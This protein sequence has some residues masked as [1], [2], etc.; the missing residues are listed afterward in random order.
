M[1]LK[2]DSRKVKK[3]DTF[4]ALRGISSD[5]H[6]YIDKAISNGA[7]YI[8]AE[9]GEYSVPYKIVPDTRE[10]LIEYL[11]LNYSDKINKLKFI[12][13]T[14]TNGKTT[15]AFLIYNSLKKLGVKV[16]YIGTI[17]FYIDDK[18]MD[19]SNTT[20][21]IY[22]LYDMFLTCYN[23]GCTYVVQEISSQGLAY[24]RVEGYFFDYA[25]F[26][27]LTE[28]HLDFHK[29]M[30]NYC[31]AKQELFKK[32]K[33]DG[34]SIINNDDLYKDKFLIGNNIITYGF[35]DSDYQV[36][37]YNLGSTKT[38]FEYK[39]L[40]NIYK[41]D[42]N[43][44][45]KFNIYNLLV[46]IIVLKNIGFDESKIYNV[47]SELKTPDG[48]L[49]VVKY[50]NNSIIIDYAHT[51]DALSKVINVALDITKGNVYTVFGCTGDRE[52]EKRP[53]MTNEACKLSKYVILTHDDPHNEDQKQIFSDM[54]KDL[55]Y[56][57]YEICYDRG[58]AIKKGIDLLNEND[59]LLIL[60]KGHE[61]Y[62][63]KNNE[64]IPFNDLE[65]VN[66]YIKDKVNV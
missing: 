26:T 17:G 30:D 37:N 48:R 16:A 45:G 9:E 56:D 11:K 31:E 8:I 40:D 18:I 7:S 36:V 34:I 28:D 66:K 2:V 65:C 6:D 53:I 38:N 49:N 22:D 60:G 32:L 3:G 4:L 13:I 43:L 14:G 61:K 33:P 54:T 1:D 21:D 41:I 52:R 62:I 19:L 23:E 20:P 25:V 35:S 58:E 57:N 51:P 59:T 10:Y 5:G 46:V 64:K 55:K 24:N 27:N 39:Y 50:E 63:I 15:T 44:I 42:T 12:G 47:I 29:T